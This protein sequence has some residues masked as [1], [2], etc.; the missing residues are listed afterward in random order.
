MMYTH[1]T[2]IYLSDEEKNALIAAA[3]QTGASRAELIRRAI[4]LQYGTPTPSDRAIA[5]QTSAG[6]WSERDYT[7][8]DYVEAVRGEASAKVSAL[9]KS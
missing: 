9:R 2:Q 1:R 3:R 6:G 8:A 7:G 5:V 4:R